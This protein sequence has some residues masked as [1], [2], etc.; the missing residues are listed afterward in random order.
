MKT[1]LIAGGSGL[2]G[3]CLLRLLL[4]APEYSAVA[5]AARRPLGVSHPKLTEVGFPPGALAGPGPDEVFCCLGTTL[6]KAG[7]REAFRG[8]DYELPLALARWAAKS[9][10]K[11]FHLV[12]SLG[13]DA[14]SRVFYS[15][16]KGEVEDAVA[17][18]GVPS[19]AIYRPALLLGERTERRTAERLA[20][21]A[22]PLLAP[23]MV[24]PLRDYAPVRAEAVALAMLRVAREEPG[25]RRAVYESSR[26]QALA[27][28][29]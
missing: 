14:R 1:A 17:G 10:A 16:V 13:A 28:S 5:A 15:R 12:T 7:S 22:L 24:G 2:V 11:R 25:G 27:G 9:G 18:A 29:P 23:F 26:I 3:G 6:A 19:I 4:E 20:Q 8:V 21:R